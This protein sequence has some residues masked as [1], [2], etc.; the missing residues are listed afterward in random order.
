MMQS[1]DAIAQSICVLKIIEH[2]LI[3][4]IKLYGKRESNPQFL[5]PKS[6]ASAC[7]A[8]P[9]DLWAISNCWWVIFPT[10]LIINPKKF[11]DSSGLEPEL[12]ESKSCVLTNYTMNQCKEKQS[13]S[14]FF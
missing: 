5:D 1:K 6:S 3:S 12:Q 9:A 14:L 8:I 13:L 7:S 4:L 10:N 11:V 2:F